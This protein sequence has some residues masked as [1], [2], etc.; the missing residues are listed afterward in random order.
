MMHKV[1]IVTTLI[2]FILL[3]CDRGSGSASVREYEAGEFDSLFH[4]VKAN[5]GRVNLADTL[6]VCYE[7]ILSYPADLLSER[8]RQQQMSC[9]KGAMASYLAK[10]RLEDAL[11]KNLE[12]HSLARSMGDKEIELQSTTSMLDVVS[13]LRMAELTDQYRRQVFELLGSSADTANIIEALMVGAESFTKEFKTD[14][15]LMVFDRLDEFMAGDTAVM[16]H[17]ADGRFLYSF[18]KGWLFSEIVDSSHAAI[19][20]LL[21][22]YNAKRSVRAVYPGYEMVCLNLGKAYEHAGMQPEAEKFYD[23]A[24]ELICYYP[25]FRRYDALE[26]LQKNYVGKQD[27]HRTMQLLPVFMQMQKQFYNYRNASMF[28]VYNAQYRLAEKNH[29][30]EMQEHELKQTRREKTLL[31]GVVILLA[32]ICV[33]DVLFWRDR[34][35]KLRV[36]FTTIIERQ[37]HWQQM[38]EANATLYLPPKT[39]ETALPQNESDVS[40]GEASEPFAEFYQRI[41]NVMERERP[42]V[43]PDFNIEVLAR[44]AGL[45]R[46]AT[47]RAIN[48]MA[49]QNFSNWLAG[50][51]VNY[52][53][54]LYM[55]ERP[56]E[57]SVETFYEQAGF[58]SRSSYYRQFKAITGMTPRQFREQYNQK[59]E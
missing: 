13:N 35:Q 26:W 36:L 9:Y 37:K 59:K 25:S 6:L 23:E 14:S 27:G 22:L 51:R 42:F 30:I 19:K 10:G 34:K 57:S 39:Q 58:S 48:T 12:G 20:L 47:S 41:L 21:P 15:A 3:S 28:S 44:M 29:R 46:S 24:T 17:V 18:H 1:L 33:W 31:V 55:K 7:R 50:Y 52:L 45:N 40:G 8:Q 16:D 49:G 56:S 4:Y 53:I 5:E 32:A 38:L 11:V 43:N 2:S 54:E